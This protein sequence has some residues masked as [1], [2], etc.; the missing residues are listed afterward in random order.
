MR[1]LSALAITIWL[2]WL[3]LVRLGDATAS[4][5]AL[6]LGVALVSASIVGWL[7][8]F[9]RLP[10]ITGY[11]IFGLLCGP[12]VANLIT[13]PM[14]RDLR[15]V[16]GFAIGIIAFIAGL[17]LNFATLRPR[18]GAIVK[19]SVTTVIVSL[20]GMA[21]ALFV[22]WRWLPFGA[23]SG[24]ERA[25][26][27][28]LIAT[29]LVGVSPILT[30]AVI[31]ESRARGPLSTM[32]T[33]V[34]VSVELLV[35]VFFAICLQVA[36]NAFDTQPAQ[37][38]ALA[39]STVWVIGGSVAF[40]GLLG[41][42]FALYLRYVGRE[43]TV[44]L[45]AL[46]ALFTGLGARMHFEPLLSGLAAGLV[47][48]N[49]MGPAGDVLRDSIARGAMPVFVL[50]FAA[51]GASIQVDAVATLS[52]TALAVAMLRAVLLRA[53]ARFGARAA[54]VDTQESHLLWRSF[55]STSEMTLGLTALVAA[56]Y[57]GW[58]G[59][60]STLMIAVVALHELVGPI[61]FRATLAQL[62]EIGG[63]GGSLV[64]VSNREPWVHDFAPDGSIR[65]RP[66]P[67]GVSVALDA[68]MRERG[69]VWIAHGAGSAD[70]EVVDERSSIEVPPDS[71]SYRLRRLWLS[72]EEEERYYAGF[73]NSALWPLCHQAHVRPVF[74]A[75]DWEAYKSVNRLFAEAVALEAPPDSSVFLNDYHLSLVAKYMRER[76][77]LLRSALFWHIPWPDADRLRICP[78]RK[79]I[80]EGLLSNDLLAFQLPRDQRNFMVS[81]T[82]ELEASV[83]G[84]TV[85]FG[86]RPVRVLAI[87][88]GA[89]FDRITEILADP[90]LPSEMRRLA[91]DLR[92]EDK[93]VGVGV[94][95]LD[96]TKG[97]PE[98]MAA[99]ERVLAER[100]DLAQRFVFVQIGVPSRTDVPAYADITAEIDEQ[101]ARINAKYGDGADNGPV[102][103]LKQA[104]QL[105]ELVALYRV[106]RF[107]IVSSLHDGMNLVA[108]EFV[109]ARDDLEGVLIL[110]E[111]A[112]AAQELSEALIINP[113]D[114]RGFTEAISRA[115]DMPGWERRRRM[116]A[117]RR[118]VAG[119]DVLAWAS[120]IL[121]RL[122]RRK[123][124]GFLAG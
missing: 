25:A 30:T 82:D 15:V 44:V 19:L 72:P 48:Q 101:V 97:I 23:L 10:R 66:T 32:S 22:L 41:S 9:L 108:K 118:R 57:P 94:D 102:R 74:K 56:E 106:A 67:G 6:G 20:A 31:A 11:L 71:P 104:F 114:E 105:P 12:A 7:F 107:C 63:T 65:A 47:V 81:V 76:R 122:E 123:G 29:L 96:Y 58:A 45:L 24:V 124:M 103:Y 55:I 38:L 110:S 93:I 40:G 91:R 100:P 64:V 120:D 53:G 60:L 37:G 115:L 88:I 34:V 121:D 80:L 70:R 16:G 85:Y 21:V 59:Q 84:E 98:R 78:W 26:A 17:Q 8:E 86:E 18:L 117:L 49:V 116:Q 51:V 50:F 77:P 3:V 5:T 113:Y 46:F 28:A 89:D 62:R 68:L 79:E 111:L 54:R 2:A 87:P 73:S 33:A 42:L 13:E 112:G 92:L 109:A 36:R 95:R 83:S 119:R 35:I 4:G 14:A 75:E 43:I 99:I 27:S 52:I 90:D 1:R 61:V 69:G 39:L